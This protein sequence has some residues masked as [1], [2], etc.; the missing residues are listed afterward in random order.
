MFSAFLD[1]HPFREMIGGMP[2]CPF[3]SAKDRTAWKSISPEDKDDL[4]ALYES[5]KD[6]PYPMCTAAQFMAFVR[7]GSR[8][9]YEEPYFLGS[10]RSPEEVNGNPL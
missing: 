7:S 10:G 4:L 8:K 6:V 9:A 2:V 1:T 3:P 5:L